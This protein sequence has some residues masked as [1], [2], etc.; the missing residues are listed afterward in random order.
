MAARTRKSITRAKITPISSRR[1]PARGRR[2]PP[3]PPLPRYLTQ[4]ELGR[5]RKALHAEGSAR[6]IVVF[7]LM[8][9]FGLRAVEVTRLL[10]EDLDVARRRTCPPGQGRGTQG[11]PAA[12]RSGGAA[13]A[14]PSGAG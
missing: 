1:Q 9:R 7:G 12:C 10:L 5:F 2:R 11:V 14:V 4:E 8:Y 13:A 6:D 3:G